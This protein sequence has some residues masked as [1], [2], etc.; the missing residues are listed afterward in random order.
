MLI[1]RY[2]ISW[3]LG[4]TA[5]CAVFAFVVSLGFEGS[6]IAM[7]VTGAAVLMLFC[8]ALFAVVFLLAYGLAGL[9]RAVRPQPQDKTPFA[10]PGELPPQPVPHTTFD[11]AQ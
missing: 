6:I 11:S 7:A 3:I 2:S 4:L 9:L 5:A 10:E 1:P 8:F